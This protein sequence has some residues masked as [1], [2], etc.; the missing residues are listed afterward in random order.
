M[1]TLTFSSHHVLQPPETGEV[2][3]SQ[4]VSG[5]RDEVEAGV[6]PGVP[7]F[8]SADSRLCLEE[9]VE[10]LLHVADDGGPALR[11]VYPV[12]ESWRLSWLE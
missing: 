7:H 10:L 5:G 12:S 3:V 6:D 8:L 1:R 11:V 2:D 9:H 4:P